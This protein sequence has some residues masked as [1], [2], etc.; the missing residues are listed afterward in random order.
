MKTLR[1]HYVSQR[2]PRIITL[3]TILALLEMAAHVTVTEYLIRV[4]KAITALRNAKETLSDGLT[5][6]MILKGLHEFYKP[7]AIHII[8][9]AGEI[10]F[11]EFKSQLRSFEETE[12]YNARAKADHFPRSN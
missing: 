2:K 3:Y 11:T 9:S 10:S 4:E 8:Q 5:I 12:K 1:E 6:A 7:F